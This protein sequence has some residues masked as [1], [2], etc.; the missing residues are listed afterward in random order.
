MERRTLVSTRL[1]ANESIATDH[2]R[3]QAG[4]TDDRLALTARISACA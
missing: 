3:F 2:W 1:S 4:W